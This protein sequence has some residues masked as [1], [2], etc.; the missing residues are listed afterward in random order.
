NYR[1]SCT[2]CNS[3]RNSSETSGGK[4]DFFPL[5][6]ERQRARTV[7]DDYTLEMP[8]LLDPTDA[9]DVTLIAFSEDGS[10]GPAD[11]AEASLDHRRALESIK[12]YHLN[13]PN[14]KERRA[15]K[16]RCVR[17]WVEEG[18][19]YLLRYVRNPA[20]AASRDSARRRIGD[21]RAE[22]SERA[23]YSAAV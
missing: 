6:D 13:H 20:D 21:I 4:Q 22:V 2:Y 15:A 5:A 11:E 7:T 8:L 10:V 17:R 1:F 19:R 16:L 12:R 18:D 9:L 23:D 14:I 3:I